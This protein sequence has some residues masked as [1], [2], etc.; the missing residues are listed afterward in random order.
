M[1]ASPAGIIRGPVSMFQRPR[2]A[3]L[4][5]FYRNLATVLPEPCAGAFAA[6]V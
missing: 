1:A 3:V 2:A 4:S 5:I 6:D